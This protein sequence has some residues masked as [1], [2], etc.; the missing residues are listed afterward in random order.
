MAE[1]QGQKPKASAPYGL[2]PQHIEAE[3]SIISAILIDNNMLL[4]VIEILA[5][6]DFY[7]S[8][9]QKIYTAIID[10]FDK[11]EPI[12]LVTLTNRLKE[13]GNLGK[14]GAPATSHAWSIPFLWR[15]MLPIMP[16]LYTT[17]PH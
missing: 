11:T 15:S 6:A 2:P 13:K 5:P 4:D 1:P 9:H 14:S 7:R 3:E 17:K 12:D 8:A 16:K 10:L